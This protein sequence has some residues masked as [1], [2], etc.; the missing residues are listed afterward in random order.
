MERDHSWSISTCNSSAVVE[1]W[2]YAVAGGLQP[3]TLFPVGLRLSLHA[4]SQPFSQSHL[5]GDH[6]YG[7][8]EWGFKNFLIWDVRP[9]IL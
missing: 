2:E 9:V 4:T 5:H 8:E 1:R 3:H 6:I 7:L